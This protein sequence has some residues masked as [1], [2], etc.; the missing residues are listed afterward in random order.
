MTQN[1][2]KRAAETLR[3]MS[4]HLFKQYGTP[5]LDLAIDLLERFSRGELV[6]RAELDEARSRRDALQAVV[7]NLWSTTNG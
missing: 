7:Q 1:K 3:E 5:E 2:N 4:A 6:E